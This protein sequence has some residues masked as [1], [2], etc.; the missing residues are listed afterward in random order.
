MLTNRLS[1]KLTKYKS[2]ELLR[3]KKVINKKDNNL[4][5]IKNKQLLSFTSNDYLSLSHDIKSGLEINNCINNY[6]SG[7]VSSAH[8]SGYFDIH[9]DLENKFCQIYNKESSLFF[10]SGYNANIGVISTMANRDTTIISDKLCHASIIDGIII[11]RAKHL[12]YEHNN[13]Q[14]LENCLLKSSGEK[15]VITESV[16]SMEGDICQID[17]ITALAKKY[18][19]FLI[20]DDAHGFGTIGKNGMGI[21]DYAKNPSGIDCVIIPLGKSCASMGA[22]VLAKKLVCNIL[23]QFARSYIYTTN[24]PPIITYFALQNLNKIVSDQISFHKLSNIIEYFI[25]KAIEKKIPLISHDLTPIK[26]ILINKVKQLLNIKDFLY[27]K[28]ILVSAIRY[29]TVPKNKERVRISL[30]SNHTEEQIN[31][32]INTLTEAMNE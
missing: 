22:I 10:N 21:L 19:A 5:H 6:G 16:F 28:G 30:N 1:E 12:R 4:L 7:S 25:A 15:I 29:P 2:L 32:L 17:K 14:S 11:S 23:N 24:I 31:F 3:E 27:K 13:M 18:G 9:R 26:S 20:I 8:I